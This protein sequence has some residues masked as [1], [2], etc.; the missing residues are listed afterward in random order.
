MS[1]LASEWSKDSVVEARTARYVSALD[2]EVAQHRR[3]P[4]AR[5]G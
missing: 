5:R 4:E 3:A 1:P 2:G